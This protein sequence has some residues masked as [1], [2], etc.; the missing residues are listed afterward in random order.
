MGR[1][2][3]GLKIGTRGSKLALWQSEWIKT[4]ILRVHP[5]LRVELVRI[6]TT[7]DKILNSPLSKIGGKGLFV[8]E[9]EE[10]LFSGRVDLAVHSMKDVPVEMPEGLVLCCYP[11]REEPRDALVS[12][13]NVLLEDLP[14]RARLGTSS[15]RR[16]AQILHI[17]PDLQIHSLRGNVDT[18]LGKLDQGQYDAIVLA[19]AGLKRLGLARRITQYLDPVQVLPAI[20]QGALGIE[21]RE[22]DHWVV[23]LLSF[24]N[25]KPTELA[26]RAERAF[27][28]RLEGGCQVP[29][30]A[31]AVL[32]SDA[33]ELTGVVA[34]LDGRRLIRDQ[35]RGQAEMPEQLG[36]ELAETV[37]SKG[38]DA[39]LAQI[40]G[41][42]A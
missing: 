18:R 7:G 40:Y 15:L 11:R 9:I 34:D 25:H 42:K 20:G 30:A 6:K 41:P 38:A 33:L 21:V 19:G 28:R 27:L 1:A 32:K 24:L 31:H 3:K 39:I 22:D 4:Q 23:E 37:L 8:K 26:V 17:R 13:G 12:R 36:L 16:S 35:K 5:D 29:I 14:A 2:R 10:A